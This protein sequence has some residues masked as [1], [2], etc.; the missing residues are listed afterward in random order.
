MLLTQL[1][2]AFR[3]KPQDEHWMNLFEKKKPILLNYAQCK[4]NVKDYY[5]AI[6]HCTEI[7]KYDRDNVKAL[8]RRAK[9][10][11]G[12]W[13]FEEARKDFEQAVKSDQLLLGAVTKELKHLDSLEKSNDLKDKQRFKNMFK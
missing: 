8:F 13:N 10:H 9:A 11:T 6:E 7:L 1:N 12:A 3:E 5:H 2:F 4:L